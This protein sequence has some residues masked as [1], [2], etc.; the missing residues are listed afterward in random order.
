MCSIIDMSVR[1]RL[2]VI[3]LAA[4]I[5]VAG[6]IHLRQMPADVLPETSPVVV[7]VPA[8]DPALQID[9]VPGRDVARA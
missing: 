7:D 1:F 9:V 2:L 8:A 4:G 6:V 3:A 5:M